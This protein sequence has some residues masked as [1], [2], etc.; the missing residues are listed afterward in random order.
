MKQ[1]LKIKRFVVLDALRGLA[2][3]LVFLYHMPKSTFLS[4]NS[5]INS[6]FIFVDL[7]FVISGFVIYH[8][9]KTRITDIVSA[10]TFFTKRIKR[11]Y[12]LH[13]YTLLI[14]VLTEIFK[15]LTINILP[16]SSIPFTKESFKTL[17]VNLFL[18]NST[19]LFEDFSWNGQSWSISAEL[20]CYVLFIIMSIFIFRSKLKTF[21]STGLIIIVGYTFFYFKNNNFDI[22]LDYDY[23]FVR[24]IIGFFTGV[25][26]YLLRT[27]ISSTK[28]QFVLNSVLEVLAVLT[29]TVLTIYAY[30]NLVTYYFIYHFIFGLTI[31]LFS[32]EKGFISSIFKLKWFQNL[33]KWSYSIYLNHVFT[34][35]IFKMICLKLLNLDG[36]L[37]LVSEIL[38]I[39]LTCWYSKMT[40][41]HI[42]KRFYRKLDKANS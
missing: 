16:Y 13:M 9:Y 21:I 11:L 39:L 1:H 20:F 15:W 30:Y 26:V 6:A 40:Y 31:Y 18:L 4:N 22:T 25:F 19:P 24:G 34:I 10:K 29:V 28:N 37:L 36:S 23:S 38:L 12:P 8:N 42:E 7:F 3:I 35:L 17:I 32:F 5:F 41:T 27:K 33:G 2:A 14:I